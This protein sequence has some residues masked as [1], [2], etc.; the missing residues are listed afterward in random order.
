MRRRARLDD[1]GRREGWFSRPVL[2]LLIGVV[3]L[4][5]QGPFAPVNWIA[6]ALLGLVIPRLLSRFLVAEV[7]LRSVP[8]A[9]R[10]LGV[11]LA[12]IVVANVRVARIVLDPGR[13]P[14]PAWVH[15]PIDLQHPGGIVLLASIVTMTP[16]TVSCAVDEQRRELLVHALD[17]DDAA[18]LAAEIKQRYETPLKEIFE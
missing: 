11:V 3:W 1:A 15:V 4:L 10:L 5:L 17:C 13:Q 18:A 7:P 8:A 12:D 14:R 6:A 2:S 16:G 9:A